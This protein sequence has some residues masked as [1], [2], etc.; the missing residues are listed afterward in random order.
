MLVIFTAKPVSAR[1]TVAQIILEY[2]HADS[3]KIKLTDSTIFTLLEAK[4][5]VTVY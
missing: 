2:I 5:T 4:Q 1:M 3:L